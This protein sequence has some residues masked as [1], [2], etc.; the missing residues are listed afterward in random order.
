[1]GLEQ[2]VPILAV[3]TDAASEGFERVASDGAFEHP[4]AFAWGEKDFVPADEEDA[5][6]RGALGGA[7]CRGDGTDPAK[8]RARLDTGKAAAGQG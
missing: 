6:A 5:L 3:G 7:G 4:D 1:M 2:G 8:L